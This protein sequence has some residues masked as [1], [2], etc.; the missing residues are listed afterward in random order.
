MPLTDF[1]TI[2]KIRIQ[3]AATA[4]NVL[5][6]SE[7]DPQRIHRPCP[8]TMIAML[9]PSR[10]QSKSSTAPVGLPSITVH[11][12]GQSRNRFTAMDVIAGWFTGIDVVL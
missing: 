12:G 2:E 4:E 11:G 9:S 7:P 1:S 8:E 3:A 5:S 10:F 6:I